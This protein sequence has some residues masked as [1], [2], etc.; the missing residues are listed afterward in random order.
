MRGGKRSARIGD[1]NTSAATK[2][3]DNAP[4]IS[5]AQIR[6]VALIPLFGSRS[7]Q[8]AAVHS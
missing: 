8:A 3:L 7:R 5:V 6:N 2:V 4:N 1:E